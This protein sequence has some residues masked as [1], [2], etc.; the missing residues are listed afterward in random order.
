M[1]INILGTRYFVLLNATLGARQVYDTSVRLIFPALYFSDGASIQ[2]VL[3]SHSSRVS[4][5][6]L[7]FIFYLIILPQYF[8]MTNLFKFLK[9]APYSA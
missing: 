1:K 8:Y 9:L 4:L 2:F 7:I 6:H 3:L 5:S